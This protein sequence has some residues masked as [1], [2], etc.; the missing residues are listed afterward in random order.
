MINYSMFLH[1]FTTRYLMPS[2]PKQYRDIYSVTLLVSR[3]KKKKMQWGLACKLW[4]KGKEI[5][6][7]P[8]ECVQQDCFVNGVSD[9]EYLCERICELEHVFACMR[10]SAWLFP[11][12]S[13]DVRCYLPL[14]LRV[15]VC[16]CMHVSSFLS[17]FLNLLVC[18]CMLMREER[19]SDGQAHRTHCLL[20]PRLGLHLQWLETSLDH[21]KSGSTCGTERRQQRGEKELLRINLGVSE[22]TGN[23]TLFV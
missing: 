11:W 17:T 1:S 12:A 6:G 14:C 7:L 23:P 4:L 21:R 5:C 2:H 9:H 22:K 19:P 15:H 18:T 20:L 16:V 13:C 10:R 8:S 3:L